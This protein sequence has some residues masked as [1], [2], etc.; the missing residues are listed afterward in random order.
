MDPEER[1]ENSAHTST[2]RCQILFS[3]QE[4]FYLVLAHLN[5][6]IN[7]YSVCE[8]E[9]LVFRLGFLQSLELNKERKGS[10]LAKV[11]RALG[12]SFK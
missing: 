5:S 6:F 7:R 10:T 12:E 2:K 9:I 11:N 4:R 8:V 1:V 3:P